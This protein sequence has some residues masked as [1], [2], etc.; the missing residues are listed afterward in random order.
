M[1]N[2]KKPVHVEIRVDGQPVQAFTVI[3][4]QLQMGRIHIAAYVGD[5]LQFA[6]LRDVKPLRIADE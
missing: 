1:A 5:D 3:D 2:S 4:G 6:F